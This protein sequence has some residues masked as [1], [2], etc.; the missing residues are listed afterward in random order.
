MFSSLYLG[1]GYSIYVLAMTKCLTKVAIMVGVGVGAE[2]KEV[3][4]VHR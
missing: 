1:L 4:F 3:R 2:D